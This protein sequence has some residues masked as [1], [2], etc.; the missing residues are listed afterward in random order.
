[1]TEKQGQQDYKYLRTA[2][3]AAIAVLVV[4]VA[5]VLLMTA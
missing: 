1:M 3:V 4:V 2:L 5:G